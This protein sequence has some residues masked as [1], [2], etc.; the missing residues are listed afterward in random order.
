MSREC[1]NNDGG[2]RGGGGGR[3]GGRGG[4]GGGGGLLQLI[5]CIIFPVRKYSW[6]LYTIRPCCLVVASSILLIF[7]RSPHTTTSLHTPY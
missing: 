1:P 7:A 5:I 3:G 4:G 2:F 6:M